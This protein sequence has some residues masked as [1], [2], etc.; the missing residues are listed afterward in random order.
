M[1][2]QPANVATGCGQGEPT[3][4]LLRRKCVSSRILRIQIAPTLSRQVYEQ[5]PDEMQLDIRISSPVIVVPHL[6]LPDLNPA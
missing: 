2:G 3:A 1:R 5:I 6:S 4:Q